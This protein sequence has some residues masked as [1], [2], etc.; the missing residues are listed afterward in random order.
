[1]FTKFCLYFTVSKK[2]KEGTINLYTFDNLTLYCAF[3]IYSSCYLFI[4]F[5]NIQ[6]RAGGAMLVWRGG[7]EG[8]G[9]GGG[10][11]VREAGTFHKLGRCNPF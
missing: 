6:S 1:M 10:E 5:E 11:V 3:I 4:W 9:G 7:E 8:L 2:T